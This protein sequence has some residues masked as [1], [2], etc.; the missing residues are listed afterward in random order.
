MQVRQLPE[1]QCRARDRRPA[2]AV[3]G[4]DMSG[5]VRED[6]VRVQ[7][8]DRLGDRLGE[9]LGETVPIV[10]HVVK[11]RVLRTPGDLTLSCLTIGQLSQIQEKSVSSNSQNQ[12]F[13]NDSFTGNR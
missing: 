11:S 7:V 5:V 1:L 3:C 10:Q 9:R 6:E 13:F 2:G 4:A 8:E 12:F